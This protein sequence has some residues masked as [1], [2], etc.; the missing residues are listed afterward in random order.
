MQQWQVSISSMFFPLVF[1][2]ESFFQTQTLSR[3]KTFVQK[4]RAKNV[5]EIDFRKKKKK[6]NESAHGN[7]TE[8]NP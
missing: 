1:L 8:I 4:I 3:E 6:K 7:P 2:Y 5:D